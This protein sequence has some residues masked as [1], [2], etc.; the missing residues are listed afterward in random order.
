MDGRPWH[1]ERG[2]VWKNPLRRAAE[3]RKSAL[4][5]AGGSGAVA[6]AITNRRAADG[7]CWPLLAAEARAAWC[8][9]FLHLSFI[10]DI[11]TFLNH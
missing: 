10:L 8:R 6:S 5:T 9:N 11:T 2:R 4:N 1:A 7:R 3:C